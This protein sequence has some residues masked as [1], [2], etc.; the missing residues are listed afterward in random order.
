MPG[1]GDV[2]V[3]IRAL[4]TLGPI[5]PAYQQGGVQRVIKQEP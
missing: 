1:I 4:V 5:P 2:V 3:K